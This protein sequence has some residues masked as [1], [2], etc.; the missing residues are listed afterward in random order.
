MAIVVEPIALA[1]TAQGIAFE[2]DIKKPGGA[3]AMPLM[4]RRL[5]AQTR[6]IRRPDHE[7]T[8]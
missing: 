1:E 2:I 5:L 6:G 7:K 3:D 4:S 8:P